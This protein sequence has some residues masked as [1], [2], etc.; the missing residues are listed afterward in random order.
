ME[1]LIL[2]P[3]KSW[4]LI[5]KAEADQWVQAG[6]KALGCLALGEYYSLLLTKFP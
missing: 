5:I 4:M 3:R 1:N 2:Q 6:V